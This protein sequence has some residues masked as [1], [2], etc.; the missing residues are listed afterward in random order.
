M[1]QKIGHAKS[2]NIGHRFSIFLPIGYHSTL[3]NSPN[4]CDLMVCQPRNRHSIPN[5]TPSFYLSQPDHLTWDDAKPRR[6]RHQIESNHGSSFEWTHTLLARCR[7]QQVICYYSTQGSYYIELWQS[8]VDTPVV[9]QGNA[10]AGWLRS[11]PPARDIK[12]RCHE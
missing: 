2:S 6:L 11:L 5:T 7:Y 9:C 3:P 8:R 12:E 1:V 10:R 4:H